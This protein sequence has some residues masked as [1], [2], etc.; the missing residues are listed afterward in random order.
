MGRCLEERIGDK[1]IVCDL[2]F[3][4]STVAT[5]YVLRER[6]NLHDR[7]GSDEVHHVGALWSRADENFRFPAIRQSE[8]LD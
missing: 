7:K 6:V 2:G 4:C 8:V 3:T 1:V 5:C